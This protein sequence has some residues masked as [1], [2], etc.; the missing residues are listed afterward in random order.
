MKRFFIF[1][2]SLTLLLAVSTSPVFV[3]TSLA[4]ELTTS[5]E[6]P[7]PN[8]KSSNK[9]CIAIVIDDFGGYERSGVREL[10]ESPVPITCAIIPFVDNSEQDYTQAIES[11]K[12]IILH[13]PMQAH[14]SLPESWYGPVY[15]ANYDEPD[16]ATQKLEKCLKT[17]P[18][19]TGFNIHI[20]SGVSRNEKTMEAMYNYANAHDIMFLDSRTNVGDKCEE[21]SQLTGSIYLGRD[22][23]LEPHKNRTYSGVL[24]RLTEARKIAE[25]KGYAIVI[26]HV[27]AEGGINTARAIIDYYN[28]N[29]ENVNFVP[30][31]A[32]NKMVKEAQFK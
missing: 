10:L 5:N 13:M 21:A 28:D 22:V 19:A 14:V 25:E 30:L 29:H 26:G 6:V 18:K 27:G 17:M 32:I 23:F 11:N 4:T 3:N 7:L 2:F 20:G 9:P 12:E 15:I 1:I 24:H 8:Q 16:V 31:S